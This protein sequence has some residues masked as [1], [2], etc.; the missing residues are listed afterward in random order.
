[1]ITSSS[2]ST[3]KNWPHAYARCCDAGAGKVASA[4]DSPADGANVAPASADGD[5]PQL[6]AGQF[7]EGTE[8]GNA[9]TGGPRG[10]WQHEFALPGSPALTIHGGIRAHIRI[11]DAEGRHHTQLAV[12]GAGAMGPFAH[13]AY[14]VL[15]KAGGVTEIHPIRIGPDT[16]PWLIFTEPA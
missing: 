10:A 6:P 1:M 3:S 5:D 13:G 15:I 12:H 7:G 2:R 11:L 8:A 9:G 14:T 16:R 4:D